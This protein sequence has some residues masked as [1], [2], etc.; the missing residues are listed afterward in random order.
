VL[1]SKSPLA[2]NL[3][4]GNPYKYKYVI[5][6]K[7]INFF[8]GQGYNPF[9]SIAKMLEKSSISKSGSRAPASLDTLGVAYISKAENAINIINQNQLIA[10]DLL[11][12]VRKVTTEEDDIINILNATKILKIKSSNLKSDVESYIAEITSEDSLDHFTFLQKRTSFNT[13]RGRE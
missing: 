9:D 13:H 5:N 1:P 2:F 12:G 8:E 11:I 3:I 7:L 10:N 4:N 6:H